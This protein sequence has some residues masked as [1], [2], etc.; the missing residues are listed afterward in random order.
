M[1]RKLY[2]YLVYH[3]TNNYD[4][5]NYTPAYVVSDKNYL[6]MRS[7]TL[8]YSF[9]KWP[10][11]ISEH[12]FIYVVGNISDEEVVFAMKHGPIQECF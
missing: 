1:A 4:P 7:V 9:V 8:K 11:D 10:N 5:Y 12:G 6:E 3:L 2:S